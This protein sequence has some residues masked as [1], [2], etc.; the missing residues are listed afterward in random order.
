MTI[1]KDDIRSFIVEN[2]LFGDEGAMISDDSSLIENGIVDSTGVL[3][4][5]AYVEE[6][7][8]VTIDDSEIVPSNLDSID[9]IVAYAA[10]KVKSKAA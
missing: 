7:L 9:A 8:G 5:V 1:S 6:Q 4:L 2:F 10:Q 3:E